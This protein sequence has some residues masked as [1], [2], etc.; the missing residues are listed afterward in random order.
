M[1][2]I[3]MPSRDAAVACARSLNRQKSGEEIAKEAFTDF[4]LWQSFQYN[5]TLDMDLIQQA[6]SYADDTEWHERESDEAYRYRH[7]S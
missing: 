7:S 4:D 6:S 1:D 5:H 2:K 3:D